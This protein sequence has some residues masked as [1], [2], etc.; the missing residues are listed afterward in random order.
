VDSE[1][2]TRDGFDASQPGGSVVQEENSAAPPSGPRTPLYSAEQN[3]VCPSH[4]VPSQSNVPTVM[5]GPELLEHAAA[6]TSAE[7]ISAQR[8]GR[9]RG[10]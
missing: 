6:T 5:C 7:A 9:T 1:A 3:C 2:R 10:S 8:I 4:V